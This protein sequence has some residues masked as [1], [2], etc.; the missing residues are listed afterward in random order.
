MGVRLSAAGVNVAVFSAHASHIEI[1]FFDDLDGE[2]R[3][4][5]P[6][7]TGSVFHGHISGITA[8]TRYGLRAHGPFVPRSGHRFNANKL[9]LDPFALQLDRAIVPHPSLF[10]YRGDDPQDG[11]SFDDR[12]SAV[13]MAKA[14]VVKPE[15]ATTTDFRVPAADTVIYELHVRGFTKAMPDVPED[16]RG[17]F[18]GLAHPAAIGHLKALGVTSVELLPTAAWSDEP[19]LTRLA[20]SNYWGYNSV[21]FFAPDPRLAPGGWSEVA[22]AVAALAHAGI[23]TILDVV[24]NHSGEGDRLGPTLSL[25]GLDNASYYRL[26]PDDPSDYVNDAGTGNVLALD[27][28]PGI[29]LVMDSLRAWRL[30]GGVAGFR[31]DLA[32]VLGRRDD[33]FDATA[34]LLTAIAQDPVL[35]EL[36]LIAEPW[37]CGPGGYQLGAFPPGWI[38]WNDRFRKSVR[39]FWRGDDVSLGELARR[40]CGSEDVFQ[41]RRPSR[42]LNFITAHDGFTLADLVSYD[43]KHNEANG[44]DNRDGSDDNSSWNHGVEG[45]SSDPAVL[46]ARAREQRNL[47]A[48]LLLARGTPMLSMGAEFGQTQHGNNNAYAQDNALSWLDWSHV[49]KNLLAFCTRLLAIRRSHPALTTDRFLTGEAAGLYPDVQWFTADQHA[50]SPQ[51]WDD[52]Q[53]Q[54]LVMVLTHERNPIEWVH[55]TGVPV[56][57]KIARQNNPLE[58]GVES[59]K[60]HPDPGPDPGYDRVLV[61]I[62]RGLESLDVVMPQPRDGHAWHILADTADDHRSGRAL[63]ALTIAARSVVV[64]TEV[65]HPAAK[66]HGVDQKALTRL[67]DAAG[68]E[69]DWWSLDGQRTEVSPET[70]I[71]LLT[72]MGLPCDSTHQALESLYHL[73]EDHDRRPL[74]YALVAAENQTLVLCV[75]TPSEAAPL[76]TWLDITG[77]SG[78]HHRVRVVSGD[79]EVTVG[80]DGRRARACKVVLPALA[81][82]RYSIRRDDQPDLACAVTITP[83]TGFAPALVENGGLAFGLTSQI[84]SLTRAGDQGIGD[85]TTLGRMASAAGRAGAAMLAINPLHALFEHDRDRASPYY[86]SDRRFLDPIY[87]DVPGVP[88]GDPQRAVI[89]YPGVWAQKSSTLEA[90]FIRDCANRDFLDFVANEGP[91]LQAFA[92]FQALS[93][94]MPGLPWQRWSSPM[95]VPDPQRVLYHQF[96]QWLCE[97]AFAG[98][99]RDAANLP[100]GLC[101]DLAVGSAPDGAEIWAMGAMIAAGVSIGAPPDAFSPSG[102]VWGL[103]PY[104]PLKLTADGYRGL[105]DLY[106]ANMRHAGALRVDHAMGLTRQFWVPDGADGSAGAYVRFPFADILGQLKLESQRARCLIIGED[107]GTVPDG[108]RE[109]LAAAK[110]LSYRVLPFERSDA[111]FKPPADYPSLS[112]ACVS[113]HDLPPLEGWWQ[114]VDISERASLGFFSP[115]DAEQARADREHE[116]TALLNALADASLMDASLMDELAA[117][118]ALGTDLAVAIHAY[119][120]RTPAVLAMLQVEDLAGEVSAVNLPGTNFERPNWRRCLG[121]AVDD[122]LDGDRAQAILATVRRLRPQDKTLD[123]AVQQCNTDPRNS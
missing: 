77:D 30:Y 82:G 59:G 120:A 85:F 39:G 119:I 91:A 96:L 13:F 68:I 29:R 40:L 17:T 56:F 32:T 65:P 118:E 69:R 8:G 19:H 122:L 72:A 15:L 76:S 20:L 16:L 45:P 112:F 4:T 60:T 46:A 102:Q 25:R 57:G 64:L 22:A 55:P 110:V 24:Y 81:P 58:R 113:T 33:G 87:L 107:L 54:T 66:K 101:R 9:L 123:C 95:P 62:H 73:A 2:H 98:A 36:K 51:A 67:A 50:L 100:M 116:K 37:D 97:A 71:H 109:T 1:C 90:L 106:R 10:G 83:K 108:F 5:L 93:D 42:S 3:I 115:R 34:P 111:G 18:A 94:A 103:P 86:P 92:T 79:A 21:G 43:R 11:N 121:P 31:F 88:P 48:T 105:G 70:Q 104:I 12:D 35:R 99:A 38:E 27:R 117:S 26:Q 47:L 78:T 7:R 53:G 41:G 114:G 63:G 44:E 74:P 6:G 84:Y 14:V 89:D 28:A 80:R 75:T 52:G 49:D 23:E 61:A